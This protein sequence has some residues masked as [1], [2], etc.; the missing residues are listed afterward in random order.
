MADGFRITIDY[1]DREVRRALD[2][3]EARSI[4][5]TPVWL[6]MKEQLYRSKEQTFR[7]EG[8]PERWPPLA[9]ATLQQRVAGPLR[10]HKVFTQRGAL[11][12]R[13]QRVLSAHQILVRSGTLKNKITQRSGRDFVEQG[14]KLV[15][16]AIHQFGGMAGRGRKVKI[17]ARPYLVVQ[18]ED[19][20][21]CVRRIGDHLVEPWE[22]PQGP[23]LQPPLRAFSLG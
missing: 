21:Y 15:Y 12:T 16:A 6:A 4:D 18:D 14:V 22:R 17:P 2:A 19:L 11:T 9:W 23:E 3:M 8:R 7:A 10:R 13:A 1:D 5:Q 20:A